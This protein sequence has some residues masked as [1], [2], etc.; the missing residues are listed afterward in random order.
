[1]KDK[2]QFLAVGILVIIVIVFLAKPNSSLTT[3]I[4][5]R[6][7]EKSDTPI[8]DVSLNSDGQLRA[9]SLI[10]VAEVAGVTLIYATQY[11]RTRQT[12]EPLAVQLGLRVNLF[13]VDHSGPQRYAKDLAQKIMSDHI[14]ETVLIVSHSNT[15]PLI[16]EELGAGMIASIPDDEY[17]DLFIIS[18]RDWDERV[19]LIKAKY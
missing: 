11:A 16:I 10:D 19:S 4:I 3:V 5:V 2:G 18:S 9:E 6:H 15:I 14:G 7:A 12:A 8:G 13:E 1:M 17:G